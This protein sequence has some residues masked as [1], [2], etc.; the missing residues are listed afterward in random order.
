MERMRCLSVDPDAIDGLKKLEP[1][2][3]PG[4]WFGFLVFKLD[5][6]IPSLIFGGQTTLL[7]VLLILKAGNYVY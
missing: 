6:I 4:I 1:S 5:T 2:H 3:P 7:L